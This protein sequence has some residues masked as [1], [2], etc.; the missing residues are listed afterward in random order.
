MRGLVDAL[1]PFPYPIGSGSK[2]SDP[3]RSTLQVLHGGMLKPPGIEL[4]REGTRVPL[5]NGVGEFSRVPVRFSA[6]Q[7]SFSSA[8]F[9][10][11][12]QAPVKFR[13]RKRNLHIRKRNL[14]IRKRKLQVKSLVKSKTGLSPPSELVQGVAMSTR[15]LR[16]SAPSYKRPYSPSPLR[17][18]VSSEYSHHYHHHSN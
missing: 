9:S 6:L 16:P 2:D 10:W 15:L 5:R 11:P 1:E 14:H 8:A 3:V 12:F 4:L 17:A 18:L 7:D 13:I